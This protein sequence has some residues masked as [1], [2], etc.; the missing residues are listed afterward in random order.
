MNHQIN[1][2]EIIIMNCSGI[3]CLLFLVGTRLSNQLEKRV[4]ENLFNSMITVTV[5]SLALELFTFGIDGRPGRFIYIGQYI[6]NALLVPATTLMGYLWCLFVEFKIFHSIKRTHKA[7]FFLGAPV[8]AIYFL[9]VLDC[10]GKTGFLFTISPSNVYARGSI[11]WI[12]YSVLAFYYLYSIVIVYLAKHKGSRIHFFPVYTYVLPCII[13]TIVQGMHYGVTAGWFAAAI[14][15]LF[16]EMQLQKEESFVDELSGLYN[17]KYLEFCYNQMQLKK[18]LQVFGIM[19]DVNLFK[20][21]N[22]TYGHTVGDDAIRTIAKLLSG[23]TEISDTVIRFAGD[24]FIIICTN[25]TEWDV[26]QL[27]NEIRKKLAEYNQTKRK[28]YELS[29]AMG[30]AKYL[31]AY[32]NLDEFLREMD[33]KMYKDK[34][35]F[36]KKMQKQQ[37]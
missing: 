3:C 33:Q 37:R 17:R 9:A 12:T 20:K 6:S 13:G 21:I 15:L 10:V 23:W 1:I 25:K 27:M 35:L 8:V 11:S 4:G 31:P 26:I 2:V 18:D 7:A 14:A 36:R 34:E 29:L 24:E 30:Y 16:V 19:I 5:L 28:P 22:D 32:T